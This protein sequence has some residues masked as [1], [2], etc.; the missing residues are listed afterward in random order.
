MTPAAALHVL[1][2]E[3]DQDTREVLKAI[4]ESD[5]IAVTQAHD[6]LDALARIAELRAQDPRAPSAIVLDFMMPRCSGAQFRERQL[7]NPGIADVPVVLVSAVSDL[8]IRA[9]ALQPF[10]VLQ[11]PI[12]PDRLT[13]IVR[14]ACETYLRGRA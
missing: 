6:G 2:V 4:L 11:K 5:G 10:A 9:A 1:L 8:P 14:R 7:A 3:D 13:A 12:D